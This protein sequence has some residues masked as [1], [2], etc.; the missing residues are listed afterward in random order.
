MRMRI[1]RRGS[2]RKWV[3]GYVF[4]DLGVAGRADGEPLGEAEPLLHRH[5][6]LELGLHQQQARR[7]LEQSDRH[8]KRINM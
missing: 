4:E 8:K 2:E 1:K 6:A 5:A 7:V 3:A